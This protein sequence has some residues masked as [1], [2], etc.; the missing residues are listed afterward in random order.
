MIIIVT[1]PNDRQIA[2]GESSEPAVTR[3]GRRAGLAGDDRSRRKTGGRTAAGAARGHQREHAVELINCGWRG[4]GL[5]LHLEAL[6]RLA[7]F[8]EHR[9]A[10]AAVRPPVF[11][12]ERSSPA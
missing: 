8:V 7:L 10:P 5:D 11:R 1:D 4:S 3:V 6:E 9:A 12:R 2:A